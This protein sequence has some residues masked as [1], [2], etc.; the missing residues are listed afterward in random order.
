MKQDL[1]DLV[2]ERSHADCEYCQ[3]PQQF[4][5]LSHE[6][7]HVIAEQHRGP[8]TADNL[9]LACYSCNKNKG[10]NISSKDPHTKQTVDLFNPRTDPWA[11]HFR[12][13]GAVLRGITPIGRATVELFKINALDRINLR[14]SLIEEGV[15]PP[16][17]NRS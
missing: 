10:P 4:V 12:W 7:D 2:W 3:I 14:R 9:A 1:R 13:E 16:S 5:E 8:T 17:A 6:V 11:D 15:F